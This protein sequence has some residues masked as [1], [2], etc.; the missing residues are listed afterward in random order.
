M[1]GIDGTSTGSCVVCMV[2]TDTGLAVLGRAEA[3]AAVLEVCGLSP[4]QAI[5]TVEHFAEH[6]LG[7]EP[8]TVPDGVQTW[9]FRLCA[10]CAAPLAEHGMEVRVLAEGLPVYELGA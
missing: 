6:E 4:E 7:C 5:A 1:T 10:Q 8:G 2:G 9:G 3:A